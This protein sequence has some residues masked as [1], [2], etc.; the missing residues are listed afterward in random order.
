MIQS[1]VE[2]GDELWSGNEVIWRRRD[3]ELGLEELGFHIDIIGEN[4]SGGKG[5]PSGLQ[6]SMVSCKMLRLR[7]AA[8]HILSDATE[9]I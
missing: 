2:S 8:E 5:F 4:R 7:A 9:K 1:R 3:E 6:V